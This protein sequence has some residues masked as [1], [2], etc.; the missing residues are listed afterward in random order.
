[1]PRALV[2]TISFFL[3]CL[4][5]GTGHAFQDWLAR[6]AAVVDGNTIMVRSAAPGADARETRVTLFGIRCP[7][8]DEPFGPEAA[9]FLR[10]NMEGH[11][12]HIGSYVDEGGSAALV[13]RRAAPP[14]S[15]ST[16]GP[17]PRADGSGEFVVYQEELLKE[18]LARVAL[19][20]GDSL[21]HTLYLEDWTALEDAARRERK[22]IWLEDGTSP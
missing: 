2:I 5:P 10:R 14:R 3:L 17:A 19:P 7:A 8:P 15:L 11:I 4:S 21:W 18:G 6:L 13:S 16:A 22:G 1:M 20:A 9:D 12:L